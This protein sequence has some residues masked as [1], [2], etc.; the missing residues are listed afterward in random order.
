MGSLIEKT[1]E[2][3]NIRIITKNEDVWF[4]GKDVASA[5][6]YS[7][8]R[9]ALSKHVDIDDKLTVAKCDAQKVLNDTMARSIV[10]INE[11]G[12]Y[13]L[14]LSSKLPSAKLFKK[15]VTSE[16]LPSIRK[17]GGYLS[18]QESKT[19]EQL[20]A[21]AVVLAHSVIAENEKRLALVVAE[22]EVLSNQF[23]DGDTIPNFCK[24][25]N[26]VNTQKINLYLMM[27]KGWLFKRSG[28]WRVA[29][30]ARDK[31]LTERDNGRV[32]L[33]GQMGVKVFLLEDGK[34]ELTKLYTNKEL[35]MKKPKK[36]GE[37]WE[38]KHS[39]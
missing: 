20:L 15:W 18:G 33:N 31:Y 17:H 23:E 36:E 27:E 9:D 10:L 13:S 2:N 8:T 24:R 34:K 26:G 21:E 11:S 39:L 38:L 28:E 22:N 37:D 29:S 19:P 5:L 30:Y 14:V 25:L 7:N 6:G 16:V 12:M 35:P 32:G 3:N 1:F 4:V